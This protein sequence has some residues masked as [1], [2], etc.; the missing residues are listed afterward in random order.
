MKKGVVFYHHDESRGGQVLRRLLGNYTGYIHCD[1]YSGYNV[2]SQATRVGCWAH[3]RRKFHVSLPKEGTQSDQGLA[4]DGLAFCN[5][6]FAIENQWRELSREEHYHKRQTIL[7]PI[8]E[9]F[10]VWCHL[11]FGHVSKGFKIKRAL[12]YALKNEKTFKNVLK[13]GD[14]VI[15]NNI[16]ERT[17]RSLVIGRKNWLFPQSKKGAEAS[18]VIMT[19]IETAK[20]HEL[21]TEK[22]LNYLLEKLLNEPNVSKTEVLEAYLLWYP[23]VQENCR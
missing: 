18:A 17:I 21:N 23:I 1:I 15:D 9:D 8:I 11:L 12:E 22:Y 3:L 7:K 5:R 10:F 20:L 4:N 19:L 16:A 13:D 2:H 6:C 14:L